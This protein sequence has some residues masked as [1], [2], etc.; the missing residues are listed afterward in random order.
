MEKKKIYIALLIALMATTSLFATTLTSYMY[1]QGCLEKTTTNL[2][3]FN[4]D[5]AQA[6]SP[7]QQLITTQ[8]SCISS[9]YTIKS[10]DLFKQKIE[11]NGYTQCQLKPGTNEFICANQNMKKYEKPTP[12]RNTYSFQSRF[13]QTIDDC[14][15]N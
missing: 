7:K 2:F 11:Q 10:N 5:N 6:F 9:Q 8:D 4:P 13:T 1:N 12:T 3:Q 14:C 15:S